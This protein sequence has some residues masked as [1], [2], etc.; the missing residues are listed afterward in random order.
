MKIAVVIA[1][2]GRPDILAA[3]LQRLARQTRAPDHVLVVGAA[4][5]IFRAETNYLKMRRKP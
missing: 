1:T 2:T 3:M 4:R 5:P